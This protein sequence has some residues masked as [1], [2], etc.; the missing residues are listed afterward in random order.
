M[1]EV[2]YSV[3]GKN[4]QGKTVISLLRATYLS[5]VVQIASFREWI[6]SSDWRCGTSVRA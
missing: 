1:S 5:N 6:S 3:R 2:R 4:L